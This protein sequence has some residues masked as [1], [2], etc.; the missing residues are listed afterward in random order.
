M[1]VSFREQ[2]HS[3]SY[4]ATGRSLARYNNEKTYC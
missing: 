2:I 3:N 1:F 4:A